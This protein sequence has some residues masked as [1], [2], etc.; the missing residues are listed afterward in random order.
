MQRNSRA[1]RRSLDHDR[2]DL[3]PKTGDPAALQLPGRRDAV[4]VAVD[5]RNEI[6]DP[7][8]RLRDGGE[9]RGR[10]PG[11]RGAVTD[12]FLQIANHLATLRG[13]RPC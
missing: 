4:A 9:D 2:L 5:R 1:L 11:A 13:D 6:V 10:P 3:G 8:A 7:L 12:Q